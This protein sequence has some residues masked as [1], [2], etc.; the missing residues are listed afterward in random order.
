MSQKNRR[1]PR[2]HDT[3]SKGCRS[4]QAGRWL[5]IFLTYRCNAGCPSCP[6]PLKQKDTVVSVF[7]ND[8]SVIL[9][10]VRS[11]PFNGI[12]FSGGECFLVFD[13]LMEWL[14]Y[15][16][17]RLPG[18]YYWTYTNG[19]NADEAKLQKL[20]AAGLNEIRFNIAATGYRS[21]LI[22]KRIKASL[23]LFQKVA[24]EVPSIP[25]DY[26]ELAAVLPHLD[27]MGVDYL[28]LHEYILMPDHRAYDSGGECLLS[29][30]MQVRYD[31]N[32][33]QNTERIRQFCQ[34]QSLR[35]LLNNC[36]LQKKQNQMLQRR[37]MM[38]SIL[39]HEY[40]EVNDEGLLETYLLHPKKIRLSD[41]R[42]W[43]R[44]QNSFLSLQR[45]LFHPDVVNPRMK[46]KAGT[47]VK[48]WFAP[49][50]SLDDKR[51]FLRAEL[52]QE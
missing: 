37:L 45:Y 50:L 4:C 2:F 34:E 36:S 9:R 44:L 25:A 33:L 47:C 28:N 22:L 21:P 27:A 18:L 3:Y 32:S 13:R 10:Y 26:G 42:E 16:K 49:P 5:C 12:S 15:F 48:L 52:S 19:L 6:S 43:C 30:G 41:I 35:I 51:T 14:T 39:K 46:E 11:K 31:R 29:S 20:A 8:P 17:K 7:G 40:E 1:S 24:V 38:G 23:P